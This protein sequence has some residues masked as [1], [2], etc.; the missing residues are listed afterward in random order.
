MDKY[1]YYYF[2]IFSA[3]LYTIFASLQSYE[4]R[5]MGANVHQSIK[6]FY[7]GALQSILTLCWIAVAGPGL[8]AF[9]KM[10]TDSYPLSWTQ[11]LAST[12]VG[13]F[14]WLNQESLSICLTVINLGT[15]S[16]FNNLA[17]LVSLSVDFGYLHR[18]VFTSD[19]AGV[20]LIITFSVA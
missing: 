15:A 14:S 1:L 20:V 8:F 11:F 18:E 3:I 6:T 19:L 7:Y 5:K 10:G 16:S 12:G 9:W 17:L 4:M 13:F 2:G